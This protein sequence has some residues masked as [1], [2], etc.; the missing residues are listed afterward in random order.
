MLYSVVVSAVY[1]PVL[2]RTVQNVVAL[3][4]GGLRFTCLVFFVCV[5]APL[6][7]V[8]HDEKQG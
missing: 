2:F 5:R 3:R 6:L 8:I 1:R 4:G 7:C